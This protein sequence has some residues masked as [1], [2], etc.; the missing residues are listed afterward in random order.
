MS[1]IPR[2]VIN[3]T[4]YENTATKPGKEHK[5]CSMAVLRSSVGSHSDCSVNSSSSDHGPCN[6]STLMMMHAT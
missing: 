4:L 6:D 1:L 5:S 2:P 3:D